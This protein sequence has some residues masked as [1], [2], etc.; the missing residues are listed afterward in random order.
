M[1]LVLL[2]NAWSGF[3]TR[4]GKPDEDEDY[5]WQTLRSDNRIWYRQNWI[6]ATWSCPSG[7]RLMRILEG[8]PDE[9]ICLDNTT[10]LVAD[11]ASGVKPPDLDHIRSVIANR[12]IKSIVACGT[13]ASSAIDQCWTG[14]VIKIPHPAYR[15][16]SAIAVEQCNLLIRYMFTSSQISGPSYL[17]SVD[18]E[19]NIAEF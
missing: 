1:L 12:G 14:S 6:D 8:I 3:Y 18:A 17:R 13:Q 5:C 15:K 16:F 11:K 7:Q 9:S 2:Q 19:G 4:V 10:L